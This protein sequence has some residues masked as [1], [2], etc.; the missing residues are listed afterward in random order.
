MILPKFSQKLHEVER[1]WTTGGW[2]GEGRSSLAPLLVSANHF[3]NFNYILLWFHF[4]Q[5]RSEPAMGTSRL[6]DAQ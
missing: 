2:G 3:L 4:L 5:V 1:I 6:I